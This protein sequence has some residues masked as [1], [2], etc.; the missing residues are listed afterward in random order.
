MVAESGSPYEMTQKPASVTQKSIEMLPEHDHNINDISNRYTMHG[1]RDGC[2]LVDQGIVCLQRSADCSRWKAEDLQIPRS[3]AK[4]RSP[5]AMSNVDRIQ[6]RSGLRSASEEAEKVVMST[7]L[8]AIVPI[9]GCSLEMP[10]DNTA[11]EG[12]MAAV[13]VSLADIALALWHFPNRAL[14]GTRYGTWRGDG[15]ACK[16]GLVKQ[17]DPEALGTIRVVLEKSAG[18]VVLGLWKLL[19]IGPEVGFVGEGS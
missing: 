2:I 1:R 9:E 17:C 11:G 7:D 8:Q 15:E 18:I 5:G 10:E 12:M 19:K 4:R 13:A 3:Q 6:T 14:K 16:L